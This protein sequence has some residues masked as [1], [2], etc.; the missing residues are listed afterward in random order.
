MRIT[1]IVLFA[2]SILSCTDNSKTITFTGTIKGAEDGT[3][4]Y[5]QKVN[6]N[7]QPY[8]IDTLIV[9]NEKI[10]LEL[11]KQNYPQLG[12]LNFRNLNITLLFFQEDEDMSA[13]FDLNNLYN[14]NVIGGKENALFTKFREEIQSFDKRRRENLEQF[15]Q[16]R[17]DQNNSE[18][19]RIQ[20]ENAVISN[21]EKVF[22]K[23]F[24]RQHINSIIPMMMLNEMIAKKEITLPEIQDLLSDR[25]PNLE[26]N[27][28]TRLIQLNIE[29]L[30][31]AEVGN[32]APAFS[33]PTPEGNIIAL[34]DVMGKVTLIDFWASWC[35]PCRLE[36][37]N[38]VR[39]HN[40]FKDKGFNIISVSLDSQQQRAQ[41]IKA[42]EDDQMNWHHIS[43]LKHWQDPIA[44]EYGVRSIPATFL[45]DETGR[46]IAK[47]LRGPALGRKVAEA[48][49]E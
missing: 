49:G 2:L 13:D 8:D 32:M 34:S 37:P 31:A 10:V 46:I 22:K 9:K 5:Y 24:I 41:W 38:V 20:T 19:V 40:Q 14:T 3:R 1:A 7:N 39:V 33:G 11:E 6:D 43:N 26:E 29:N 18:I 36:N 12:L 25:N 27:V 28:F 45:L 17:L 48:I 42:I 16:A 30:K 23:K 21:E 47:N 15:E 44:K 35:K 4:I